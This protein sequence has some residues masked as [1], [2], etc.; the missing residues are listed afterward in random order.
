[1]DS[2]TQE[3]WFRE[4]KAKS[5]ELMTVRVTI[6]EGII[7]LLK[8]ESGVIVIKNKRVF[9]SL[10]IFGGVVIGFLFLCGFG[11]V[12]LVN[13]IQETSDADG[14][15]NLIAAQKEVDAKNFDDSPPPTVEKPAIVVP[16]PNDTDPKE[17]TPPI[18]PPADDLSE[19]IEQSEKMVARFW[20]RLD[21]NDDGKLDSDEIS[22]TQDP[23]SMKKADTDRD[24]EISKDELITF[25]AIRMKANAESS[26]QIA[27][28]PIP[29]EANKPD[30]K[31]ASTTDPKDSKP[32]IEPPAA[33][34][35]EFI[36]QSERTVARFW[37]IWDQDDNGKLAADEI[38]PSQMATLGLRN[39]DSDKDGV[40]SKEE[41]IATVAK[42]MKVTLHYLRFNVIGPDGEFVVVDEKFEKFARLQI[43]KYDENDN[44]LLDGTE[45]SVAIRTS[46]LINPI[47]DIN[48]NGEI[49]PKELAWTLS[50]RG[51][52]TTKVAEPKTDPASAPEDPKPLSE[53]TPV[54]DLSEFMELGEKVLVVFWPRFDLNDDG[55]IDK[56]EMILY[57]SP[58]YLV[59]R[60]SNNDD[61]VTKEEYA[62]FFA[63]RLK[64]ISEASATELADFAKGFEAHAARTL[65]IRDKNKNGVLDGAEVEL[66]TYSD[67]NS[68]GEITLRELA[69]AGWLGR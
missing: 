64:K 2:L 52:G 45:V 48:S 55:K 68:D 33:D 69:L 24:G 7:Y 46:S 65:A 3:E 54:D 47:T 60:D 67:L 19:F 18:D 23:A 13:T 39:A 36:E 20:P 12:T 40:I 34:V 38:S 21:S 62:K 42:R 15:S 9:I 14:E 51:G 11:L 16:Q 17:P 27:K 35:S 57:A 25:M 41:F 53:T 63:K 28:T 66:S 8:T 44:G 1:M 59:K 49:N 58:T 6:G 31:T 43:R 29:A 37:P 61:V 4:R 32:P 56:D 50:R 22:S 30:P 5:L 26:T 10:G